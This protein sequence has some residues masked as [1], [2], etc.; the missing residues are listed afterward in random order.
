M[1]GSKKDCG[2]SRGERESARPIAAWGAPPLT[3]AGA[4]ENCTH[5]FR[6]SVRLRS[7]N[8]RQGCPGPFQG[9]RIGRELVV[10]PVEEELGV[11]DVARPPAGRSEMNTTKPLRALIVED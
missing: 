11:A 1:S 8:G 9:R 4:E 5:P 3:V 10:S 2:P 7:V 6:R